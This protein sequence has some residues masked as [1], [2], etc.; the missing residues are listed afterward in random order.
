M[1]SV[2]DAVAENFFSTLECELLSWRFFCSQA[3]ARMARFNSIEA[4][5]YGISVTAVLRTAPATLDPCDASTS[6]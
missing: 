6:T 1:S 4:W 2:D 5:P 3:E